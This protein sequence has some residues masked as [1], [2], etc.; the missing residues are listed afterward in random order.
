MTADAIKEFIKLAVVCVIYL[1]LAPGLGVYLSRNRFAER[2]TLAIMVSMPSW[3]PSKLTLMVDSI[4]FYRG[5]TKGFEFSIIVATGIALCV[6]AALRPWPGYRPRPPGFWFY[7]LYCAL[8]CVSLVVAPNKVYGLMAAWKFTSAIL[9]F[10]G[11]YHAFQ[12]EQDL[13]WVLRSLAITLIV[14]ALVCLKLR[15]LDGRW[16]VHGWFEHQNPMAM[17]T[18]MCAIPLLSVAFAPQI[19]RG[20]TMLFLGGVAATALMILLSVSRGALAAFAIGAAIVTGMAFL[21]GITL[22]KCGISALGACGAVAAATLALNSLIARIHED[23]SRENPED[24]RPILNRQSLYMLRD[25]PIGI[26]WNNFGIVNSLPNDKYVVVLMDWDASR[27]FRIIDEMYMA[28][29]LTESLFWLVLSETGYQG[30]VSYLL[31][32]GITLWWALRGMIKY[33]KTPLGYFIGGVLVALALTYIHGTVER[34]LSQTK[35]MSAWLIFCGFAARVQTMRR[36]P[37][38]TFFYPPIESTPRRELPQPA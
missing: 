24:L 31:F 18:Y 34:V 7:L 3:F 4:E 35:N 23:S 20:D 13:L 10:V 27:G 16:Q 37:F 30:F 26:G 15:F 32:M 14:Q 21:R 19:K 33:W 17:W 29:P 2:L 8:A 5:H 9:I 25:S 6:S 11:A 28:G 36:L 12:D 1:V 22:K 38:P